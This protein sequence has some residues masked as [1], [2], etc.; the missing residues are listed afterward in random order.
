MSAFLEENVPKAKS[1]A[2]QLKGKLKQ[3][4]NKACICRPP[5][6][7]HPP[8]H[9]HTMPDSQY[10]SASDAFSLSSRG[11]LLRLGFAIFRF[12]HKSQND[13]TEFWVGLGGS[14]QI[15]IAQWS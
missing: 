14:K 2:I 10:N 5:H 3:A 8:Q 4:H 1:Y 7:P 15:S 11:H 12:S 6:L 13:K 9:T